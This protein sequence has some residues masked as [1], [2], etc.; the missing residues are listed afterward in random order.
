MKKYLLALL[1]FTPLAFAAPQFSWAAGYVRINEISIGND[2]VDYIELYFNNSVYING[3]TVNS[4]TNNSSSSCTIPT[5]NYSAGDYYVVPSNCISYSNSQREYYLLNG[6]QVVHYVSLWHS[7]NQANGGA[8][9]DPASFSGPH[10]TNLNNL[11]QGSGNYCTGTDG[12]ASAFNWQATC[13]ASEGSSNAAVVTPVPEPSCADIFT[14]VASARTSISFA[15]N[16]YVTPS[17]S[18]SALASTSVINNSNVSSCTSIDCTSTGAGIAGVPIPSF[19][20]AGA[21]SPTINTTSNTTITQNTNNGEFNLVQAGGAANLTFSAGANPWKI[22]AL[23]I[24]TGIIYLSPGDYYLGSINIG[25]G[26]SIALTG[27]GPVRL[28]INSDIEIGDNVQINMV[29]SQNPGDASRLII[30]SYNNYY[31]G[32]ASQVAAT[33]YAANTA[34]MGVAPSGNGS[35]SNATWHYGRVAANAIE[36][37][38]SMRSI[39]DSS[40]SSIGDICSEDT[41]VNLQTISHWTFDN[42]QTS[43]ANE[44]A[45][46]ATVALSTGVSR[47]NAGKVCSALNFDGSAAS[48]PANTSQTLDDAFPSG[49]FAAWVKPTESKESPL[50]FSYASN[51]FYAVFTTNNNQDEHANNSVIQFGIPQEGLSAPAPFYAAHGLTNNQM[52]N[53]WHHIAA[54]WNTDTDRYSI[55][56]NGQSLTLQYESSNFTPRSD[57]ELAFGAANDNFL[58][59]EVY[60]F[61]GEIDQAKVTELIN[62]ARECPDVIDEIRIIHDGSALTCAP[63][64]VTFEAWQN[65]TLKTNYNGTFDISITQRGGRWFDLANQQLNNG[66]NGDVS[67]VFDGSEGGRI[68]LLLQEDKANTY[69]INVTDGSVIGITETTYDP[70]LTFTDTGFSWIDSSG[71]PISLANNNQAYLAGDT[72]V[73]GIGVV[74]LDTDTESCQAVFPENGTLDLSL[75]STCLD[76]NQCQ[77]ALEVGQNSVTAIANPQ[78]LDNGQPQSQQT[79]QLDNASQ[80]FGQMRLQDVGQVRLTAETQLPLPDGSNSTETITGSVDLLFYPSRLQITDIDDG[81]SKPNGEGLVAGSSWNARIEALTS[82]GQ[83]AANFGNEQTLPSINTNISH[84][85]PVGGAAGTWQSAT[86]W[87]SA[88]N[89]GI[90]AQGFQYDEVGRINLGVTTNYFGTTVNAVEQTIGRFIPA[91]LTATVTS[92]DIATSCLAQAF[93]G[94]PVDINVLDIAI[95]A[96]GVKDGANDILT[97]NYGLNNELALPSIQ[98]SWQAGVS[99]LANGSWTSTRVNAGYNWQLT[100]A[101]VSWDRDTNAAMAPRIEALTGSLLATQLTDADDVCLADASGDC[102]A[103]NFD[104]NSLNHYYGQ[105]VLYPASGSELSSQSVTAAWEVQAYQSQSDGSLGFSPLASDNCTSAAATQFA[106]AGICQGFTL[107][108]CASLGVANTSSASNAGIGSYEFVG[109]DELGAVEVELMGDTWLQGDFNNDGSF[110]DNSRALINFGIWAGQRPILYKLPSWR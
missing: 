98:P 32:R 13:A 106:S 91:Y 94:Q 93:Y 104:S 42:G 52:R 70:P 85:T 56:L 59:D 79:W 64:S 29:A 1:F 15:D 2:N 48:L 84:A 110:T 21:S 22:N 61:Q 54:S 53:T 83:V 60:F 31:Q 34:Y 69:D 105:A 7:G 108:Q 40:P 30:A 99:S 51:Q 37:S 81:A 87:L 73:V 24:G 109:I 47:D 25:A 71:A 38:N 43:F 6:S 36:Y 80:V 14:N 66:N 16:S 78:Q 92:F 46:A 3:W 26:A 9:G 11:A 88:P 18:G 41:T 49:S 19:Q 33:I 75:S 86:T 107:A 74:T 35:N 10:V 50:F 76:P 100:G 72:H 96:Y 68:T 89:N 20:A 12:S 27:T 4:N 67:Y 90:T 58:L 103:V 63:E 57:I 44:V 28:F 65:G 5:G 23:S 77:T 82:T 55:W 97:N 39:D 102:V 62:S 45:G 95:R 101:Q 17:N 8:F